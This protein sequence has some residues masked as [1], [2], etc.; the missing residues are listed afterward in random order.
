MTKFPN[1]EVTGIPL[2]TL[3]KKFWT[4]VAVAYWVQLLFNLKLV[5]VRQVQTG[6]YCLVSRT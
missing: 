2:I 3:P 6:P 1:D 4:R 5:S